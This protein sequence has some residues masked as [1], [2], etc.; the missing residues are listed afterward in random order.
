MSAI[1]ILFL[2]ALTAL[3]SCFLFREAQMVGFIPRK[4]WDTQR[5]SHILLFMAF[6]ISAIITLGS[7]ALLGAISG[8]GTVG[9]ILLTELLTAIVGF[10]LIER[11]ANR[12]TMLECACLMAVWIGV[13][14]GFGEPI[15]QH[16]RNMFADWLRAAGIPR[17]KSE[18]MAREACGF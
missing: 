1:V 5:S 9:L 11:K 2:G 6:Q 3:I 13:D 4:W 17:R 14:R 8:N 7:I 16:R 10:V 12:Q 18:T 15:D